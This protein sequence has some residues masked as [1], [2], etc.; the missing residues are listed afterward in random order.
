M[1][2]AIAILLTIVLQGSVALSQTPPTG[3]VTASGT[4]SAAHVEDNNTYNINCTGIG[5]EQGKKIIEI[6]NRV[7]ANQDLT[8]VGAKLD[9]LLAVASKPAQTQPCAGSNCVQNGSQPTLPTVLGLA[10]TPLNPR[11][12]IGSMGMIEGPLGVNPGVTASFT[13]DS[14]FTT[15]MFS[16]VCDRPCAA[17]TAT[18]SAGGTSAPQ[19]L[20]TDKP[21]IAVVALG[22]SGPL[23]PTDKVTIT[24]RSMDTA[25][26]SVQSVQSYVQPGH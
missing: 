24:V 18:T 19:M 14:M 9:E 8:T 25:K 6:L 7:L 22:L 13:V 26:I 3:E 2:A 1:K 23:M 11:P 5:A 12:N 21:N 4:C 15:A 16:V 10:V 20:T 17:T